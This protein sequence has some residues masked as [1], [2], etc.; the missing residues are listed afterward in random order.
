[1]KPSPQ[2]NEQ[3]PLRMPSVAEGVWG[4]LMR[5]SMPRVT[6][7][8]ANAQAARTRAITDKLRAEMVAARGDRPPKC[9]LEIELK[10]NPNV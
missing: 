8:E 6:S 7:E 10:K 9:T 2:K 4:R 1:M 5:S 3:E